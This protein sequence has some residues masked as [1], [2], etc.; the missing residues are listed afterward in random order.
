MAKKDYYEV[1]GVAKGATA[2][3]IK[4]AYRKKAIEN[5]PDKNPDNKAAEDRFK[6]AAE[7][8]EILSNTD[9]RSKYDQFGHRAFDGGM[10][11]GGGGGFHG[12]MTMEDIFSS[13]GDVFGGGG[14]PFGNAFNG[15]GGRSQKRGSNLRIKLKLTLQEIAEGVSKKVKVKRQVSC[16]PCRG[17]GAKDGTALDSCQTCGGAGQVRRIANTMLGQMVTSSTCPACGGAGKRITEQCKSCQGAGVSPAEET[18]E[19]KIPAGVEDEMQLSMQGKGNYPPRGG[20]SGDL[21]IL[22]EEIED[23]E[24]KRDGKNIHHDLYI[25]F[26]DAAL[27]THIEV[28]TI[29]GKVKIKIETGTQSGKILR[30]RGKG[31]K[32]INGFGKGDQLIH[33]NIWTPQTLSKKEKETLEA[34]RSSENFIPDPNRGEKTF[35]DKVRDIFQ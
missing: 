24:L 35:F 19:L 29:Q 17:T 34:L 21:I 30:L 12:G 7:A 2:T 14:S 15:G 4:K 32:D 5:H 31:L 16:N 18:I 26:A 1:L 8:Y 23:Q 11:G 3:E 10:G 9:K 25:N 20:V 13:F 27:G 28:P 6:E 33:I 22:I